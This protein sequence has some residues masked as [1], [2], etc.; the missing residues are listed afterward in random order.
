MTGRLVIGAGAD[1]A[2]DLLN[3]SGTAQGYIGV[4]G[5]FGSAP[6]NSLRLRGEGGVVL[7]AAGTAHLISDSSGRI[8]TPNQV[9]WAADFAGISLPSASVV[10]Y[11]SYN[12]PKINVGGHFNASTGAMTA[13]VSGV[14][15][16]MA[17]FLRNSNGYVY[18]GRFYKNGVVPMDGEFRTTEGFSGYNETSTFT[19][20]ISAAAG[21]TLAWGISCDV[22][23][24]SLY[25]SGYNYFS[26]YLLG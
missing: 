25:S 22:S 10:Y 16:L 2:I 18:R 4:E 17:S 14:Y 21:D 8:R 3:N 6:S 20:I 13:P 26:G 12:T 1:R 9:A 23:G 15:L 7:G 19:H 5:A 24:Q 11:P